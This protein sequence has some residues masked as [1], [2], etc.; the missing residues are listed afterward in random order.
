MLTRRQQ[1]RIWIKQRHRHTT[2]IT[3]WH[4]EHHRI[5]DLNEKSPAGTVRQ[6]P[7][8]SDP[9]ANDSTRTVRSAARSEGFRAA[10]QGHASCRP[11][12]S[13]PNDDQDHPIPC[14]QSAAPLDRKTR[15]TPSQPTFSS[16]GVPSPRRSLDLID[17]GQDRS[18]FD[19][20]QKLG[21]G[22]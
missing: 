13:A 1:P 14:D 17:Q 10:A 20:L 15:R 16:P 8:R 4:T 19:V 21:L 3:L 7:P 9:M 6:R 2:T 18:A 12:P 11:E 22:P 5:P